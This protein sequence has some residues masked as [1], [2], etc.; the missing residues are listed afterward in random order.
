MVYLESAKLSGLM[1]KVLLNLNVN[2]D[3]IKH[4]VS[5][6][7]STSLRGTDSHGI[8][9]FPHYCRAI[10]AGR[11]NK[12]PNFHVD[13]NAKGAI[14]LD[15]DHGFGHHAGSKAVELAVD[16]AKDVGLCAVSVANS[17]H[18]G[19]AAYFAIQAAEKG[20]IGLSFTNA[21]ALVKAHQGKSAFF[22][23]N[24]VCFASPM[25]DEEPFCLDMATSQVSWN[26]I[27][28]A[29]RNSFVL[30][31]GLAYNQEGISIRDP[32]E[33]RTLEPAG[34]YKGF[35]LGMMVDILCALLSGC[36]ISKDLLPMYDSP[37][38]AR[39]RIS[40]F[41]MAIDIKAFTDEETFKSRLKLMADSIRAM[42]ALDDTVPVMVAGDPEKKCYKQR[43][44]T[45]IP[46]DNKMFSEF[47]DITTSFNEA[48][49][50]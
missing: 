48:I 5:S 42:P 49:L 35:G 18:F 20:C 8:N 2:D 50:N 7:V 3:A 13:Y 30:E 1:T 12:S 41:F 28:N 44:V 21:D 43:I 33:A 47:L 25:L 11:I 19:A 23:T 24:P 39:R 40:H 17:S 27:K 15:A 38:E 6:L 31:E 26:Y 32:L 22:G 16:A 37:I 46:M 14:S 45:G 4:V 29:R 34:A 9:L 10:K 36:P